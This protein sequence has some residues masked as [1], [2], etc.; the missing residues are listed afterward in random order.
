MSS[1][2]LYLT[3]L[4]LGVAHAFDADHIAAVS[5]LVSTTRRPRSAM[6][7]ALLWGAG[8]AVPVTIAAGLG[9]LLGWAVAPSFTALAERAV[10]F[11]LVALGAMALWE[12][13]A[14][15][16]HIH[17][18]THGGVRHTHFHAHAHSPDDHR[19]AHAAVLTGAV[20]GLAGSAMAVVLLPLGAAHPPLRVLTFVGLFG[21]AVAVTMAA[22]AFCL[23]R[24]TRALGH[25]GPLA[26]AVV[27]GSSALVC[28]ALGVVWIA[29]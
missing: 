21:L 14:R 1:L 6:R 19:H 16:I 4:V 15:G 11:T 28:L 24:V 26:A 3:P 20:H 22:Y 17:T 10:G 7:L 27:R 8:H 12:L 25:R 23:G 9:M 5:A 18:H 29:R 13:R 2:L